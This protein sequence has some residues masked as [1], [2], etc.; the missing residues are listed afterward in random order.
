MSQVIADLT[1]TS[2]I[3]FCSRRT[4]LFSSSNV[5]LGSKVSFVL[6]LTNSFNRVL[7]KTLSFRG[8]TMSPPSIRGFIK[9]PFSVPQSS[10]V[11]TKSCATSTNLLVR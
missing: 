8:S 5:P 10:S 6:G 2:S 3:A 7:P 4:T 11:T 9:I 1:Q